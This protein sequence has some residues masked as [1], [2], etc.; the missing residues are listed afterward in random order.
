[1]QTSFRM[2]AGSAMIYLLP[3]NAYA[4]INWNDT[5][6]QTPSAPARIAVDENGDVDSIKSYEAPHDLDAAGVL[7]LQQA[8]TD[9]GYYDGIIDG[10][11]GEETTRAVLDYQHMNEQTITGRLSDQD[12]RRLGVR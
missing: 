5:G 8:L 1:M 2:L 10:E 7:R 11:W 3:L 4:D 12:L 9:E 6:S